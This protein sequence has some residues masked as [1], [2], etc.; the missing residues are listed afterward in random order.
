MKI[1]ICDDDKAFLEVLQADLISL[2]EDNDRFSI[3]SYGSGEELLS[4]YHAGDLIL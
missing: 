1:A 4:D 2:Q 3:I